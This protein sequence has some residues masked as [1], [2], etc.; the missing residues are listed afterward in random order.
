MGRMLEV[1]RQA[2]TH[3]ASPDAAVPA[4][5]QTATE[6]EVPFIEWGPSKSME[7]SASVLAAPAPPRREAATPIKPPHGVQFRNLSTAP[8]AGK[9]SAELIAFHD[10]NHAVSA[11][12]RDLLTAILAGRPND[13]SQCLLFTSSH[14]ATSPTVS[15]LN[16]AITAARLGRPVAV[17]D[18][19]VTT[20]AVAELL[21]LPE[22]PGLREVL[23]GTAPLGG[24]L[25]LTQQ[26]GLTVLTAGVV[27][28]TGTVRFLAETL[29]SL[30][31]QLRQRFDLVLVDAGTW[32]VRAET[33]NL[34]AACDA[35]YLVLPANES[36]SL[37]VD[38]LLRRLP[39]QGVNLAGC[40]VAG[41]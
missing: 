32:D 33:A 39:E 27:R 13:A 24:A 37:K 34:A 40:I 18:G 19:N 15:L 16:V 23:A 31:R 5:P 6:T 36:E 20:P 29:R 28:N 11:Q 1:L 2:E 4:L 12:Y 7:A 8:A 3:I 25:R 26:V 30:L 41:G 17:V 10:A 35:V 21:G 38:D 9:M 22:Q 14:P